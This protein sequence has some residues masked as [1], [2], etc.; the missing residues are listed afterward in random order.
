MQTDGLKGKTWG[1]STVHQ[2]ERC[3]SRQML[4]IDGNKRWSKSAPNLEKSPIPLSIGGILNAAALND[5]GV[6]I[7]FYSH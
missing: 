5:S 4:L 3:H 6:F 2:K 7:K 1:P